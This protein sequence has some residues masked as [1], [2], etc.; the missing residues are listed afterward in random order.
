MRGSIDKLT[1]ACQAMWELL[2]ERH[3]DL[4]DQMLLDKMREIDLRDGVADGRIT[5]GSVTCPS[6]D[7]MTSARTGK[8][9]YCGAALPKGPT[10]FG[11]R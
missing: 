10:A 2:R 4:T 3:D 5:T 7:R 6:C 8:C 11:G 9:Q 1:L